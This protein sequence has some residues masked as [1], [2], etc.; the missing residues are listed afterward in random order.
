MLNAFY[1]LI[2]VGFSFQSQRLSKSS[3]LVEELSKNDFAVP[4]CK[5]NPSIPL[6]KN[7]LLQ[8]LIQVAD[9]DLVQLINWAKHIPGKQKEISIILQYFIFQFSP[10]NQTEALTDVII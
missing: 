5:L 7:Y 4:E 2:F 10:L 8:L 3:S 6:N 1:K 9:K